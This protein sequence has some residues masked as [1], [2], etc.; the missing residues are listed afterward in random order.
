[1]IDGR[2]MLGGCLTGIAA[3]T[4]PARRSVIKPSPA[5]AKNFA[6][7]LKSLNSKSDHGR[8]NLYSTRT[9]FLGDM[10]TKPSA[11]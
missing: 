5:A 4:H 11:M 2:T 10:S 9:G 3:P 1:L 7:I 6:F 8:D